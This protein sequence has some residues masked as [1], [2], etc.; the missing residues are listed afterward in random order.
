MKKTQKALKNL[1][2]ITLVL[3]TFIACDKDF[4]SVGTDIIGAQNF[5]TNSLK[6]P[7]ITY[8]Q[9]MEPVQ[10]SGLPL[11]KLGVYNDP[12]YGTTTAG[13]LSQLTPSRF[14]P[15]FGEEP[16]IESVIIEIPYFSRRTG[17]DEDGNGEY[18]LDSILGEAPIKLTAYRSNYFL[19]D[20]DPSSEFES[21]QLYFSNELEP[22]GSIDPTLVEGDLIFEIMS[23]TASSDEIV[24]EGEEDPETQETPVEQR[25]SPRIRLDLGVDDGNGVINYD[26]WTQIILD[27]EGEP[28]LSNALNFRDYFRGLYIKAE[29]LTPDG[30]MMLLDFSAANITINYSFTPLT[31]T[32]DTGGDDDPEREDATYILNFSGNRVNLFSNNFT[33]PLQDGDP[34]NGDASLFI[35]GGEGSLAVINLFEG[36][37]F[38]DNPNA[39]N[40]FESFKKEFVEVEDDLTGNFSESKRLI[41]EANIVFYVNQN[42]VEGGEEEPNRVYLYDLESKIPLID[43]ALDPSV[44]N[45]RP[46]ISRALH[47]GPLQRE[48]D[49]FDGE[50]IKYKIKITEHLKNILLRDST[51]VSLG[52]AVTG[53][54]NI[55]TVTPQNDLQTEETEE[56]VNR[57]PVSSVVTPRGTILHG[58]NSPDQDKRVELEIFYTEPNNN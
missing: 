51:N 39:D 50:G 46:L 31:S 19:R 41:N 26:Y 36:L 29:A 57:V 40:V 27:M 22:T 32:D 25:L 54:I 55:E 53:N 35:K 2:A 48:G 23:F 47:L 16:E 56:L 14:N 4:T 9:K 12:N 58:N 5:E 43:Y 30:T 13:F 38:D 7:V 11:N 18:E 3:I 33:P 10:T 1:F 52:L 49:A 8:S 17:T 24:I 28:E 34:V 20:F 45:G 21:P 42:L 37:N 15:N 6:Y 44:N